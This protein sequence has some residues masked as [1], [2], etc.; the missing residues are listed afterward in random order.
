MYLS[1]YLSVTVLAAAYLV[2]MSEV[3]CQGSV[4]AFTD[5]YCVDFAENVS[6]GDMA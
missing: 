1:V 5:L 4:Y 3:R 2:C 6:L